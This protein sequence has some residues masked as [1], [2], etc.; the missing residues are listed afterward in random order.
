MRNKAL[1]LIVLVALI[2]AAYSLEMKYDWFP[3]VADSAQGSSVT[4]KQLEKD[5]A[6]Q[7]QGRS[8]RFTVQ[9]SGDNQELSNSM[10]DAIKSS[11]SYDDYTAYI[12]E[13]YLYTIRSWGD[14]ST[15][16]LEARYRES[17]EQ[18]EEVD[19]FVERALALIIKPEMND[20]EKVKVIHDWIVTKLEYDQSLSKYTAYEGLLTGEA[21]CQ[22][23]SLLGYKMLKEAGITVRIAEGTVNT[24]DHAWNMVKLGDYWYH[25]DLTW[26]DPVSQEQSK[27]SRPISYRY[28]LKTDKQLRVDHN[29]VKSYPTADRTY[30]DELM[31]LENSA[32]SEEALR[33]S[34]LKKDIGLHW[35]EPD[36]TINNATELAA[37]LRK[38]VKR[39]TSTMQF[40]YTNGQQLS[41]D[42]KAAF[43]A[44]N[45]P[46]GY[47]ANYE[48]Y[49]NDGSMLVRI[50]VSYR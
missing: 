26:D 13:S 40:R 36:N 6:Q 11:L 22:G 23:Y 38:E 20:H 32:G 30:A 27:Q 3:V 19:R 37:L 18:T 8:E 47:S 24:G 33:Y 16:K 35:L 14:R 4:V 48:P 1:K 46:L 39:N 12:I 21:V 44:V 2:T 7:F 28:Y 31:Q 42:L 17:K 43:E 15:I 49:T 9:Y 5:L 34:S 10:K 50:E 45:V 25:L 29:W 41:A